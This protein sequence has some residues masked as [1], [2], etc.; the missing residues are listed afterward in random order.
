MKINRAY[1]SHNTLGSL[2]RQ[3]STACCNAIDKTLWTKY[4]TI[5]PC[6][7]TTIHTQIF[8]HQSF[9]VFTSVQIIQIKGYFTEENICTQRHQSALK[10]GKGSVYGF[11]VVSMPKFPK[12]G[13]DARNRNTLA[14]VIRK[15]HVRII[16]NKQAILDYPV[17]SAAI[18]L[19]VN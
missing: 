17:S 13:R 10:T 19:L 6:T 3:R 5:T 9:A 14:Q 2:V 4:S 11:T 18:R 1:D 16:I 8:V 12:L 15:G 7:I